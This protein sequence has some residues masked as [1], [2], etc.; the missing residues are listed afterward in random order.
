MS[1]K[2]KYQPVFDLMNELNSSDTKIWL[3]RGTL[4]VRASVPD[5]RS[6]ELI[7]QKVK[8]VNLEKGHDIDIKL[9]ISEN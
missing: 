9:F 7:K 4:F 2:D 6:R 1:L 5:S 8:Q 3:D